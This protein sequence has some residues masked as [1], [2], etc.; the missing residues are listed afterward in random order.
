M[1]KGHAID[2]LE[3]IKLGGA[4]IEIVP[5]SD[6]WS[7]PDLL[8][9]IYA[10]GREIESREAFVEVVQILGEGKVG[11]DDYFV[12]GGTIEGYEKMDRIQ[13]RQ[14]LLKMCRPWYAR[15]RAAKELAA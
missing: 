8:R 12:S 14:P 10:L 9:A 13:L 6:V 7:R 2:D 15:W 3:K 4:D 1:S 11:L 5:D